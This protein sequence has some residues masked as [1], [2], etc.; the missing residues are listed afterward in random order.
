MCSFDFVR[1]E[2]KRPIYRGK[3]KIHGT[4]EAYPQGWRSELRC[5]TCEE[6]FLKGK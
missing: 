1:M 4:F 2:G 6:E 5:P 3:C